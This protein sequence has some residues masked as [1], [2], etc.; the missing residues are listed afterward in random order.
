MNT[1]RADKKAKHWWNFL[2]LHPKEEFFF[3]D[4]FGFTGLPEFI[5]NDNKKNINRIFYELKNS[6]CLIIN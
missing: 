1:D 6:T 3:F 4:S 5:M 2:D